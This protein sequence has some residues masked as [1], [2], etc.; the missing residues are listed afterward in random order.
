MAGPDKSGSDSDSNRPT[1]RDSGGDGEI[2][3]KRPRPGIT[4]CLRLVGRMM[5][6]SMVRGSQG[7]M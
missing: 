4:G 1:S 3:H 7:P 6:R 2:E 5:D